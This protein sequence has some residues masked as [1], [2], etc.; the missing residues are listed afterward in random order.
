M[1]EEFIENY[2]GYEIIKYTSKAND[3]IYN[4]TCFIR[5]GKSGYTITCAADNL[6]E[7]KKQVDEQLQT[8][9]HY[10]KLEYM[11]KAKSGKKR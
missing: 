11:V 3:V 2:R 1:Q 4:A 7:L 9:F 8:R 6:E 10:K 5:S